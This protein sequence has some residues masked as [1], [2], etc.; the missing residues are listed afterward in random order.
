MSEKSALWKELDDSRDALLTMYVQCK[1]RAEIGRAN[2]VKM[3][4]FR[5]DLIVYKEKLD[6]LRATINHMVKMCKNIEQYVIDRK[7]LAMDMLKLAIEK[8]GLIVPD[9]ATQGIRLEV[10]DKSASVVTEDGQD[11]NLREGSAYRTVMGALLRFT[12]LKAMPDAM[13]VMLLDEMFGTLSDTTT[14]VMRD[15][16]CAFRDEMLVIGI[17]QHN[18]L[19]NGLDRQ[20][21]KVIKEADGVSHIRKLEM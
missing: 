18:L 15:F 13:Q 12:L 10:G 3:K 5:S 9:A 17:E 16:L 6:V 14:G 4:Q 11:V 20:A 21:F 19:Y 8:A 7:E 2:A 1:D